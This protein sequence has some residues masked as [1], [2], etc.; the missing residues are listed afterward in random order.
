MDLRVHLQ[1]PPSDDVL[2]YLKTLI[3]PDISISVGPRIEDPDEVHILVDGRPTRERIL[4][5]SALEVVIIPFA[6]LPAMTR[7]L[8]LG[9]PQLRVYNL[10]HNA[11]ATAECAIALLLAA[12]K[13]LLP[14]DRRFRNHDWTPRYQPNPS[15]LLEGKRALILGYGEIGGRVARICSGLGLEICAVRRS[16]D[17]PDVDGDVDLYPVESLH[18]LL[19]QAN[20]L[21]VCL[22]STLETRGMIGERELEALPDGAI[23]VNVARGDIIEERALFEALSSK[24]LASAGLDVWYQYPQREE[25]RSNTSPSKYPFQQ[26]ENVVMSPHR[27][28]GW[29]QS[30]RVRIE[31]LARLLNCAA[32]NEPMEHLVDIQRG[33]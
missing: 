2:E 30:E 11:S 16:I 8:L 24:K 6:G 22:P 14:I 19:R 7:E 32:R 4:T 13:F 29:I 18:S 21:I 26:L 3:D 20:I 31:H 23:V 17:E 27:A 9:F 33:Y 28:G 1:N 10:H 25:D 15:I 5:C 12:A